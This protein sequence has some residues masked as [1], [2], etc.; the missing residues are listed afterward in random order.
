LY[1]LHFDNTDMTVRETAEK[2][3]AF[4]REKA[5]SLTDE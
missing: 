4:A 2:V 1:G 3:A 5:V